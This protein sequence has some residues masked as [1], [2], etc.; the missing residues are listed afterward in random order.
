MTTSTNLYA[1]YILTQHPTALWTFEQD[2]STST[3]LSDFFSTGTHL[4]YT[5]PAYNTEKYPAFVTADG[6][7]LTNKMQIAYGSTGSKFG[8]VIIPAFGFLNEGGAYKTYTFET[9]VKLKKPLSVSNQNTKIHKLLG[10]FSSEFNNTDRTKTVDDGNGLYYSQTSFILKIGSKT[11]KAYIKQFNKPILIQVTYTPNSASLLVNGE[12]RIAISLDETD[13]Q[14][15][16][17]GT[18]S[19]DYLMLNNANIDSVAIYPYKVSQEQAKLRYAAGQSAATTVELIN[20]EHGS[21]TIAVDYSASNTYSAMYKFPLNDEW[22]NSHSDNVFVKQFSIGNNQYELP[23][24]N[25]SSSNLNNFYSQVL[26]TGVWNP[27]S[28]SFSSVNSHAEFESMSKILAEPVKGFFADFN[29]SLASA[30]TTEKTIFKIVDV[31]NNNY[32]KI[33]IKLNGS[34]LETYYYFKYNSSSEA[35][36]HTQTNSAI[37]TSGTL[38]ALVGIDIDKFSKTF[39]TYSLSQFFNNTTNLSVF[40]MGDNDLSL[41][42]TPSINISSV[43]FL[44]ANNLQ[45]RY[46]PADANYSIVNTSGTFK[47]IATTSGS[48]GEQIRTMFG[49]YDLRLSSTTFNDIT[50]NLPASGNKYQKKQVYFTIASFG[51]WKSHVPLSKFAKNITN[52]SNQTE[53]SFDFIQF[54]IDYDAPM[55]LSADGYFDTQYSDVRT[56]ITFEPIDATYKEDLTFFPSRMQADRVKTSPTAIDIAGIKFEIVDGGI[57]YKPAFPSG[58]TLSDYVAVIHVDMQI[59]DTIYNNVEIKSL[60]LSSVAINSGKENPIYTKY[61]SSIIPYTY[62]LS[63][64]TKTYN[65]KAYNPFIMSKQTSPYLQLERLSG[66]KLVGFE[67]APVGVYRG[68]KVPLNKELKNQYRISA[69]QMFVYYDALYNTVYSKYS[70]PAGTTEI[71]TISTKNKDVKFSITNSGT[72]EETATISGMPYV[73]GISS[74]IANENILYYINGKLSSTPTITSNEWTAVGIVFADGLNLNATEGAIYY[75]GPLAIDNLAIYQFRD[76]E[77]LNNTIGRP[78]SNVLTAVGASTSYTWA[79]WADEPTLHRYR[80]LDILNYLNPLEPTIEISN[81]FGMYVG[82]NIIQGPVNYYGSAILSNPGYVS[83][84]G[85]SYDKKTYTVS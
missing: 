83:Y 24:F 71:M 53:N 55:L 76:M 66:I 81:A 57:I 14:T 39:N 77:I 37:N 84:G 40:V 6:N 62:T 25:Y 1:R 42:T 51:Y 3:D 82:T 23:S 58:K 61:G 28:G 17:L 49:S 22:K 9:W 21:N 7:L 16:K 46:S 35:L 5:L 33:N 54:N 26:D 18:N 10:A 73:N 65:Y 12:E 74:G 47:R 50:Y 32:F 36:V 2:L 75:Y 52:S 80:W 30:P 64:Q 11:G 27:K 60:E 70:M 72:G 19:K 4:G 13:I 31:Y 41:D 8:S 48:P 38:Y 85:T 43:K 79:W 29:V 56:Y 15:L 59:A 63:G 78:W 44:T 67:Y 34:T 20:K 45:K 68:I 69:V